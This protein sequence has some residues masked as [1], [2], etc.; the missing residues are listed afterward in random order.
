MND[1]PGKGLLKVSGIL[2]IIFGGITLLVGILALAGMMMPEVVAIVAQQ[3]G[4]SATTVVVSAI[5]VVVLAAVNIVAGILGVKNANKPEKAQVC[6]VMAV[7]LLLIVIINAILS[8]VSGQ[9]KIWTIVI[10]FVLPILYLVGA[11]KN[12]EVAG[13][14]VNV[15]SSD[16][17]QA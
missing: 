11:L 8:V 17:N 13:D 9:F 1:A 10:E 14:V 3:T 16:D 15:V 2:L 7:I 5:V 6:F 4:V 12:K